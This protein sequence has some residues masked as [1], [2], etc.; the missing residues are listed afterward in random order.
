MQN[1]NP[2]VESNGFCTNRAVNHTVPWKRNSP[3]L[4]S[5]GLLSMAPSSPSENVT[6]GKLPNTLGGQVHWRLHSQFWVWILAVP[7][8]V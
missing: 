8:T 4:C 7:L 2:L 3:P 6:K 1:G 5:H